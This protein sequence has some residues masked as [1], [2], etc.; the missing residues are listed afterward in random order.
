MNSYKASGEHI[1]IRFITYEDTEMIVKW[2]NQG[3]VRRYFFYRADFTREIHLNWMKDKVE[4]GEV[5]QFIICDNESDTPIGC[6]YLRDIDSL[7]GTAEYGVFIGD[8]NYRGHGIGKEALGLTLNYAWN[9]LKLD[10]VI[11]RAISTNMA[12]IGSFLSMGFSVD[13]TRKDQECS[14]GTKEDMVLMSIK[15]D[16]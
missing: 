13:E 8:E 4:T 6:T 5:V 15:N 2:R 1:Y 10:K 7:E 14:D 12:S 3:N 16:R 11:S 9:V